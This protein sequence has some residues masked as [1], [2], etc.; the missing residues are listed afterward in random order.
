MT[1]ALGLLMS[2]WAIP[3]MGARHVIANSFEENISS[4]RVLEKNGFVNRGSFD[5]GTVLRG[6]KKIL[7]LF[8][9]KL[10]NHTPR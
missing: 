9:W 2:T 7:T 4:N 3:R 6:E 8:E 1:A 10:S 5:N